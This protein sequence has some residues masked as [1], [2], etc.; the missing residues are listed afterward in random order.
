MLPY[1]KQHKVNL[2]TDVQVKLEVGEPFVHTHPQLG[3][4]LLK[5]DFA[6]ESV[7][8]H[9]P[10]EEEVKIDCPVR[11]ITSLNDELNDTK[12]LEKLTNSLSSEDVD[13]IYR[14][15]SDHRMQSPHD[16]ELFLITLDRMIKDNP[17]KGGEEDKV[18]SSDHIMAN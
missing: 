3:N 10:F 7:K 18:I 6:E 8:Y 4:A 17:V 12:S 14:K 2:P 1:Y 13:L 16:F 15:N 9:I 11:I 5:K